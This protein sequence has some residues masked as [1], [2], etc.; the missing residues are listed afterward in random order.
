VETDRKTAVRV[1]ALIVYL[2]GHERIDF[3]QC[4]YHY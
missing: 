4:R 3:L 1:L 2:A